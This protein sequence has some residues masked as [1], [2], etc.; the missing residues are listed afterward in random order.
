MYTPDTLTLTD[1]RVFVLTS[2][3]N[4]VVQ[5]GA[6]AAN[7]CRV[8][9]HCRPTDAAA[10]LISSIAFS[11]SSSTTIFCRIPTSKSA[12]F[13]VSFQLHGIATT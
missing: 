7:V 4:R 3:T 10:D 9:R 8:A 11:V 2:S 12:F 5:K 13:P 6:R 1:T